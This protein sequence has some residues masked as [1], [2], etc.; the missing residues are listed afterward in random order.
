MRTQFSKSV[1]PHAQKN[2]VELSRQFGGNLLDLIEAH[3]VKHK[4]ATKDEELNLDF[5]QSVNFCQLNCKRVLNEGFPTSTT[6][7][8]RKTRLGCESE[9]SLQELL[10]SKAQI[11]LMADFNRNSS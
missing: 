1:L 11:E 3:G 10:T 4:T 9:H 5:V 2:A 8:R 7:L 6:N